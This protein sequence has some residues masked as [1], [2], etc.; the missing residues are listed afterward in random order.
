M[1]CELV[2]STGQTDKRTTVHG[3][4]DPQGLE[5][6]PSSSDVK[7]NKREDVKFKLCLPNKPTSEYFQLQPCGRDAGSI[8]SLYLSDGDFLECEGEPFLNL[9]PV[10]VNNE[11]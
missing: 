11:E 8:A 9:P 6:T 1:R 7:L 10:R 2:F 5:V 4:E 3:K